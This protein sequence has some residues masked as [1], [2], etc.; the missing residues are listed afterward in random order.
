MKV[1]EKGNRMPGSII[2]VLVADDFEPLRRCVSSTLEKLAGLQLIGE[3]SDGLVALD[4]AKELQ[5]DILLLDINLPKLNGF[6]VARRLRE[7]APQLRIIFFSEDRSYD[8]A[9]EALRMG[10][11][12][13]VVKSETRKELIPAFEAVLEGKQFVSPSLTGRFARL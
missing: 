13:Y 3:A 7:H 10:A 2:R 11:Y 12:G 5:P 9:E 6:E 1:L 4:K 8:T